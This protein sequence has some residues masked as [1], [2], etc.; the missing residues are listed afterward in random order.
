MDLVSLTPKG[1]ILLTLAHGQHTYAEL[2]LES[3]LSDRWLTLKLQELVDKGSA[4]KN[5]RWYSIS[6]EVE[7]SAY[8][9]SFYMRSQAQ[10]IAADLGELPLVSL[11]VLFGSVAQKKAEEYSD[12]D[13]LIVVAGS[14]E[15]A[16]KTVLTDISRFESRY[17]LTIEPLV[18]SEQDFFANLNSKE[19]GIIFGLADAFEVLLDKN[20]NLSQ[21]LRNQVQKIRSTY[22]R[23]DEEG[24]WLRAK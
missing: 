21:I 1:R 11:V 17:H 7:V 8:E 16:K 15:K 10:R 4:I 19:G 6:K 13:L 24:I 18:F 22:T 5:G 14:I 20:R 2:K 12:L 23:V 3:G 9:L